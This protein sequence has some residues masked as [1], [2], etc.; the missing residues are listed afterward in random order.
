MASSAFAHPSY[1]AQAR[2]RARKD[3]IPLRPSGPKKSIPTEAS[4]PLS[5][6]P[7]SPHCRA[8]FP[9]AGS[10]VAI[11]SAVP[12][13]ARSH[14]RC[15]C[16]DTKHVAQG[17][18]WHERGSRADCGAHVG[19]SSVRRPCKLRASCSLAR[20]IQRRA[21]LQMPVSG[22]A[23]PV[24]VR[25]CICQAARH[26]MLASTARTGAESATCTSHATMYTTISWKTPYTM[27][28]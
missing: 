9:L 26:V 21:H 1:K 24:I 7:T 3:G 23:T 13:Q 18:H 5:P 16:R 2:S 20:T 25:I 17:A 15:S 11:G 14:R 22:N 4:F 28:Q 27:P 12:T 10:L 6:V 8:P 19:G